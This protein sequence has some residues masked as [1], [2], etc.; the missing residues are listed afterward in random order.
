MVYIPRTRSNILRTS[1]CETRYQT[2]TSSGQMVGDPY[3]Y[4]IRYD[5]GGTIVDNISPTKRAAWLMRVGDYGSGCTI[6]RKGVDMSNWRIDPY[7]SIAAAA[8]S[9]YW[10]YFEGTRVPTLYFS[11]N[12]FSDAPNPSDFPT[13]LQMNGWGADGVNRAYP[14]KPA[15]SIAQ[16]IAE[17]KR[18]GLPSLP[19][20]N[21]MKKGSRGDIGSE[22]LNYEFGI[23]PIVND[24][25]DVLSYDSDVVSMLEKI[26]RDSTKTYRNSAIVEQSVDTEVLSNVGLSPNMPS[27][28]GTTGKASRSKDVSVY[29]KTTKKIWFTGKF[30]FFIPTVFENIPQADELR[31]VMLK[32]GTELTPE[33]LW[34]LA[35]WSWLMD[36]QTNIGSVFGNVS[37]FA[38][39]GATM[40]Y[41]YI[42]YR[43]QVERTYT[44]P[45]WGSMTV[46]SITFKRTRANPFGFGV[47][48]DDL[49]PRQWAIL[50]AL[51]LSRGRSIK[52]DAD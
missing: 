42:M 33:L 40:R 16:S 38:M 34:E 17:L 9:K 2:S 7:E 25:Q 35:P 20:F 21:L 50:G 36:W 31:K 12:E 30:Q 46:T 8:P 51:G 23:K 26:R 44:H 52:N 39:D 43:K 49:N 41:G 22:Y 48:F 24:I 10:S 37:R 18:E 28:F 15:L 14:I 27:L 13:T 19:V 29:Q 11:V 3:I 47:T 32:T 1:F 4:D 45:Y 5:Q 6:A